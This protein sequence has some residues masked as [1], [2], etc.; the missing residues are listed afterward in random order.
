MGAAMAAGERAQ[1]MRDHWWWRPGWRAGRRLC[2]FHVTF[3]DEDDTVDGASALR[4]LVSAYQAGLAS[5][6]GMG[7][8]PLE[9]LHL[10]MQNVGFADEVGGDQLSAIADRARAACASLEPFDLTFTGAFVL[11]EAVILLPVPAEPVAL[12]RDTLRA[13]IV[14]VLGADALPEA[15]EQVYGF[16]P[17]VS[18]G[19][20]T[21]EGSAR[22]YIDAVRAVRP[23]PAT[24]RV[25]AASLIDMH[26]DERIYDWRTRATI[27]L[28][29]RPRA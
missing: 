23:E 12:L 21:G 29:G 15:P 26:R 18:I 1:W 19:Y 11:V 6:P 22:P 25:R 28:G 5:L 13:A 7:R 4:R 20:A 27:P 3:R 14:D 2:T 10:T 17:H 16:H 8:V 24:V 9:S